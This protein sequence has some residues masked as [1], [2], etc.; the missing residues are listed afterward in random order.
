MPK[1]FYILTYN[2]DVIKQCCGHNKLQIIKWVKMCEREDL[3]YPFEYPIIVW[4]FNNGKIK[5]IFE[6]IESKNKSRK[7]NE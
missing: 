5:N 3:Y 7:N 2:G 4:Q 6:I 1:G